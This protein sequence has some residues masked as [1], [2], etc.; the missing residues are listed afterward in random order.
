MLVV[1]TFIQH[2]FQLTVSKLQPQFLNLM[3][4]IGFQTSFLAK[5]WGYENSRD[6]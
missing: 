6:T 4:L 5:S 1:I 3:L 2:V